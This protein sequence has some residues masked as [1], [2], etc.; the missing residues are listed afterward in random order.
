MKQFTKVVVVFL[1]SYLLSV[2]FETWTTDPRSIERW[3][4]AQIGSGSFGNPFRESYRPSSQDASGEN[5]AIRIDLWSINPGLSTDLAEFQIATEFNKQIELLQRN[6]SVFL[7]IE[8]GDTTE[9]LMVMDRIRPGRNQLLMTISL[10]SI[11]LL[12]TDSLKPVI[13]VPFQRDGSIEAFVMSEPYG[14][15]HLRVAS[16][17]SE[18]ELDALVDRFRSGQPILRIA[19]RTLGFA[20][21]VFLLAFAR[22]LL[23]SVRSRTW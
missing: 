3:P 23:L 2:N 19:I 15:L 16:V 11:Q 4:P 7:K 22:H 17:S 6:E 1:F 5:V 20:S 12:T 14:S 9:E 18:P 10:D 13:K 8:D 21:C